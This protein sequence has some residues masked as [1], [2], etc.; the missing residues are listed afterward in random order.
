MSKSEIKINSF[1]SITV[2][3]LLFI[4]LR[5][6]L[7]SGVSG[8]RV[9]RRGTCAPLPAFSSCRLFDSVYFVFSVP[10]SNPL[11]VAAHMANGCSSPCTPLAHPSALIFFIRSQSVE[12]TQCIASLF[13]RCQ[14]C[15]FL[16][17]LEYPATRRIR[18][19]PMVTLAESQKNA[20]FHDDNPT[21]ASDCD[22]VIRSLIRRV[23]ATSVVYVSCRFGL[24]FVWLER[25]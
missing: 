10:Q 13:D 19:A 1:F 21:T 17:Q 15:Q 8:A 6:G 18:G 20:K 7:V 4:E 25:R 2:C 14:R 3:I 11:F 5:F 24:F 22:P 12:N 9:G 23:R 16:P